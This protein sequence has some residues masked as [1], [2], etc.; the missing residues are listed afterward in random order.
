MVTLQIHYRVQL[1]SRR[2][3]LYSSAESTLFNIK[4]SKYNFHIILTVTVIIKSINKVVHR[5]TLY[6]KCF[7]FCSR[8][9]HSL[10][11]DNWFSFLHSVPYFVSANN[12]FINQRHMKTNRHL[13]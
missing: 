4:A 1:R 8:K 2:S 9:N 10:K 3:Y 7:Q 13:T 11:I 5:A 12:V 6:E